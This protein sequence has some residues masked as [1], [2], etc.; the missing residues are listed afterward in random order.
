MRPPR[1]EVGVKKRDTAAR[2][3]QSMTAKGVRPTKNVT[4]SDLRNGVRFQMSDDA[5]TTSDHAKGS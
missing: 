5:W 3:G 2:A 4:T 1:G